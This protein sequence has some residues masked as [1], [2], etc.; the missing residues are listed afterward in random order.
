MPWSSKPWGK[1]PFSCS[2]IIKAKANCLRFEPQATALACCLAA[3]NAGTNIPISIAIT[4]ITTSN[5]MSV[6]A[7]R[8]IMVRFYQKPFG[9]EEQY[10][11]LLLTPALRVKLLFTKA[12][13]GDKAITDWRQGRALQ[14]VSGKIAN[15]N[16]HCTRQLRL[17]L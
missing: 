10:P 15:C 12:S 9:S 2:Y 11:G 3:C 8:L 5:S 13:Q 6:K 4:A 14:K 1:V 7:V 17:I 16:Q